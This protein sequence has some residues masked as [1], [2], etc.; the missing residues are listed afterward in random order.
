MISKLV[1]WHYPENYCSSLEEMSDIGPELQ[2]CF[3]APLSVV[4]VIVVY[5]I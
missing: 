1:L 4:I 3:R 5:N 2:S